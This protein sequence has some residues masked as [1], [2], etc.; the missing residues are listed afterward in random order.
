MKRAYG[1]A[2]LAL[3]ALTLTFGL[4]GPHEAHAQS[5]GDDLEPSIAVVELH[6]ADRP[7]EKTPKYA[8]EIMNQVS[9]SGRF[10]LLE[11]ADARRTITKQMMSSSRRITEDK[12]K[13]IEALMKEG[14]KLL[15]TNPRKAIQILAK[16]KAQL[17]NVMSSISLNHKIRKE[18]FRT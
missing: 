18:F 8:L 1:G 10:S 6:L 3:G 15:L 9:K 4:A 12:L 7:Y 11:R 2:S 16:A 13:A 17:K 5:G 14:D